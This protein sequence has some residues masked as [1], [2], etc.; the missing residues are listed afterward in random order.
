M[1]LT[2]VSYYINWILILRFFAEE[3]KIEKIDMTNWN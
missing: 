1:L 3:V 2:F